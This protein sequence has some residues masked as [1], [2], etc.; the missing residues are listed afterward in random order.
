MLA[1]NHSAV[2]RRLHE[3]KSFVWIHVT[4]CRD[5]NMRL[6]ACCCAWECGA[7][8]EEGVSAAVQP[9]DRPLLRVR[10]LP[11]DIS[12]SASTATSPDEVKTALLEGGL[13]FKFL[14]GR[15]TLSSEVGRGAHCVVWRCLRVSSVGEPRTFALKVHTE[16]SSALKRELAALTALKGASSGGAAFE[17]FPRIFGS[18]RVH[19]RTGLAMPLYGPDLY[20][21]QKLR[22]RQPFAVSFVWA[23]ACQLLGALEA[24][25]NAGLVHAD[26][27]PQNVVLHRADGVV[28][29]L[30][31]STHIALIDLGSCLSSE[32]LLA[33]RKRVTYVQ[34]RWYRAPEVILWSPVA[35]S[36]DAWSVG[37]VIA[38]VALGV[39]LLPGESEY[40]QL[41]RMCAMFGPPPPSLL[42]RAHRAEPFFECGL[43]GTGTD[44]AGA[45][46][47]PERARREPPLVRYLP[48][49]EIEALIESMVR[50]EDASQ[51]HALLVLLD[52]LLRWDPIERWSGVRLLARLEGAL[53]AQ[54]IAWS[55]PAASVVPTA[56]GSGHI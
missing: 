16:E 4:C 51:R 32:Q 47:I 25:M 26:I 6:L 37:C 29:A 18:V 50:T 44:G 48:T 34:S 2:P 28:S 49:D 36:A 7:E 24:L 56:F 15:Y 13:V 53:E 12:R 35:Q 17:L 19:G 40:N 55:N 45:E 20:Q 39:P 5:R 11:K 33:H 46:L 1:D 54:G 8:A 23:V 30:D 14:G 43:D 21:L 27:K 52:G 10:W 22:E 42:Q 41:S 31:G 38:E 3:P 9:E